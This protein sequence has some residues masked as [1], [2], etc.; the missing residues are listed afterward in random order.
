MLSKINSPKLAGYLASTL[1]PVFLVVSSLPVRAEL[2]TLFTTPK[3]RQII[4][5]NRYK[6]NQVASNPVEGPVAIVRTVQAEFSK[7]YK[8]SGI[9]IANSPPYS[10]WINGM[11]Y[12]DGESLPDRS[13]VQ[14]IATGKPRVKITTPDGKAYYGK[15]G[16]TIEATYLAPVE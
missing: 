10:A 5:N 14:I 4:N 3:E 13:R 11:V 2:A 6:T 15:S 1:L 8:I 9:A 7:S 12:Q 16:E